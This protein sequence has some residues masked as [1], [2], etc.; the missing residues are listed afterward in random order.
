MASYESTHTLYLSHH[1]Q[2]SSSYHSPDP[3]GVPSPN[4]LFFPIPSHPIPAC[5]S[6]AT[7]PGTAPT[8]YYPLFGS[9][10]GCSGVVASSAANSYRPQ[11]W[12]PQRQ[13][14]SPHP[15]SMPLTPSVS[16]GYDSP[17][18][19]HLAGDQQGPKELHQ[20]S[21]MW[22]IHCAGPQEPPVPWGSSEPS[23][24]ISVL[25]ASNFQ[26]YLCIG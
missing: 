26:H 2:L 22:S 25:K 11:S 6:T 3:N 5:P 9:I 14:M 4:N 23:F 21:P 7:R 13:D 24:V 10:S 17:F 16:S 12:P 19:S 1:S 15:G 20:G 18:S 8:S